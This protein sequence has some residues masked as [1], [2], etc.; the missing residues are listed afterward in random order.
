MTRK[1]ILDQDADDAIE[2]VRVLFENDG[3]VLT[4]TDCAEVLDE[5]GLNQ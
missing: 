2:R 4:S 3:F 5:L 1:Q